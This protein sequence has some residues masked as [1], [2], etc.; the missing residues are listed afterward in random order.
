MIFGS[1]LCMQLA[2][3]VMATTAKQIVYGNISLSKWY[4]LEKEPSVRKG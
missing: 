3:F 1:K 4:Y 2:F